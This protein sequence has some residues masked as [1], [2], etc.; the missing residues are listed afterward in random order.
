[1]VTVLEVG[2]EALVIVQVGGAW[3]N[4]AW[5]SFW[6]LQ[7]V[8][9]LAVEARTK[10][11]EPCEGAGPLTGTSKVPPGLYDTFP[12]NWKACQPSSPAPS[13]FTTVM[14]PGVGDWSTA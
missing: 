8:F 1:M 14:V 6:K 10:E 7:T 5:G 13:C 12:W 9:E 11:T 2:P 4:P 3:V